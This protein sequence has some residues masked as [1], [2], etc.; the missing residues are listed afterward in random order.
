MWHWAIM[1]KQQT[2]H[3]NWSA[4]EKCVLFVFN[5]RIDNFCFRETRDPTLTEIVTLPT[6]RGKTQHFDILWNYLAFW[7]ICECCHFSHCSIV[8][9][10]SCH[11]N[12]SC[13]LFWNI[14][15][16]N[17]QEHLTSKRKEMTSAK[18]PTQHPS[19]SV[20]PA[21]CTF[22]FGSRGGGGGMLDFKPWTNRFNSSGFKFSENVI[23]TRTKKACIFDARNPIQTFIARIWQGQ[24]SMCCKPH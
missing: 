22:G 15:R 13:H 18:F 9:V 23:P 19:I 20:S 24:I 11:D 14:S 1:W 2:A 3:D 16:C 6:S 21:N 10:L 17:C 4:A 7:Q 5:F 12:G 8:F